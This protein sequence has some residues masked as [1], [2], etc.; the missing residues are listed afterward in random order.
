MKTI[1]LVKVMD[2]SKMCWEWQRNRNR[3]WTRIGISSPLN[4]TTQLYASR[5][6]ERIQQIANQ[7]TND[8][9]KQTVNQ[10]CRWRLNVS[11]LRWIYFLYRKL[12]LRPRPASSRPPKS[13]PTMSRAGASHPPPTPLIGHPSTFPV[14]HQDVSSTGNGKQ[15]KIIEY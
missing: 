6:R 10:L 9:Q 7:S 8:K 13:Q 5:F 2:S 11:F 3:N 12:R 15:P 14:G 4:P 1:P